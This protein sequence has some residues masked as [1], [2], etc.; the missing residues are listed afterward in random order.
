MIKINI[1]HHIMTSVMES[2]Y[3]L[4]TGLSVAPSLCWVQTPGNWTSISACSRVNACKALSEGVD[5][6]SLFT[7]TCN[8]LAKNKEITQ[9]FSKGRLPPRQPSMKRTVPTVGCRHG[10]CQICYANAN[11]Q[12]ICKR[13]QQ[14]RI[15]K[16][17]G[18]T[19]YQSLTIF[20]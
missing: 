20:P 4:T 12:N 15:Q 8:I 11:T 2:M 19:Q 5:T 1:A 7:T 17:S 18:I 16:H 3:F 6:H 10:H 14:Y 9:P 13:P